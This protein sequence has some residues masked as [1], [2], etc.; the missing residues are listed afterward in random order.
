MYHRNDQRI[1]QNYQTARAVYADFGVDTDMAMA[2]FNKIPISLHCWQGDDVRGFENVGD[3]ASQN[4]VTGHYPGAARTAGELR[5]DIEQ[6][7]RLSPCRRRVN[8]HS[9]Y[10]EPQ[11]PT[12]RNELT[13]ADFAGW[14]D[15][16]AERQYGLDFNAS[17]FTHPMMIDGFSLASRR[18]DVR[19]YWIRAARGARAISAAF[20]RRLG[21]PCVHNIWIPD[22]LKDIPANRRVY[23]E[24]LLDSLDQIFAERYTDHDVIDVLEGKLFGIGLESYTA[25]SH[26]FYLAYAARHGLGVC[27]DT[28]HYHPT[29]SVVDKLSAIALQLDHVLLHVSRGIRWDSDHVLIQ[30][31]ELTA[32]MQE[33]RRGGFFRQ[34]HIG[35]DYFDASINRV[36]AWVIGLRAAGKALLTAWLEPSHLLEQAEAAGDYTGRLALLEE[37]KNLPVQAVWE[38]LCLQNDVPVSTEWLQELRL[39]E[40]NVQNRR[41]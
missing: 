39:Y 16:A 34:V 20:G 13:A 35:L 23:R 24:L 10:A 27:L 28:G 40:K 2:E 26:E 22:G 21:S 31:D 15:W 1:I 25:G 14:L 32:L 7:F 18:K 5:Q 30:S 29:E 6:A 19:D 8:L 17:F 11:R 38:M 9:I 12:P 33:I 41:G 4:L 37:C 3:A 36:A